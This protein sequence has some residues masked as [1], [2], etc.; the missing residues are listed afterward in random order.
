MYRNVPRDEAGREV[1]TYKDGKVIGISGGSLPRLAEADWIIVMQAATE[2]AF[3]SVEDY[4]SSER[5]GEVRHE[6]LG[7]SLHAMAGTSL[8][9]NTVAVNIVA[10]LHAHLRGKPRRAFMS[11]VKV[12]LRIAETDIFYYPDVVVASDPREADRFSTSR[13]R[14]VVEVLSPETERIDRREK[15]LSYTQIETLK[16]Y[17]L[18]AQDRVEM[19]LFRRSARWQPEVQRQPQEQLRLASI[20]FDL[21]LRLVYEGVQV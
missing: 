16:E 20:D 6:Y 11:G 12:R 14:V 8:E 7:G 2:W 13:P 10:A 19:T 9:H 3:L 21:P 15:F 4:L 17:V 5:A 18:V 1:G